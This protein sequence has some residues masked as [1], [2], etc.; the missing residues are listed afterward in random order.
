MALFKIFK[1]NVENLPLDKHE[2][3]AYFTVDTK[4]LYIDIDNNT[5]VQVNAEKLSR[6]IDN[7]TETIEIDDILEL[8]DHLINKNNP[9]ETTAKQVG[10]DPAGSA[11]S[12]LRSAMS[13]VDEKIAE[14]PTPD[15]SAQIEEHNTSL[16]AH[17]NR[18]W[19]SAE[20]DGE[21]G[22]IIPINADTLNGKPGSD[23][24]LKEDLKAQTISFTSSVGATGTNVQQAIDE[25]FTSA[26]NGK[27]LIADAITG[28][29]VSTSAD[30]TYATMAGNIE[31]IETGIDISDATLTAASELKKDIVAYSKT[32]KRIVGSLGQGT[33]NKP[34]ISVSSAGKITA[35]TSYTSGIIG[36]STVSNT[37]QLSTQ[38][39]TTITP[40]T[41]QK[42]AVATGKY[43]TGPVYVAGD[44][45]LV[46]SNIR[47]GVSIFG[48]SGSYTGNRGEIT[49]I[50]QSGNSITFYTDITLQSYILGSILLR[51]QDPY[52]SSFY[53]LIICFN[54]IDHISSGYVDSYGYYVSI[55]DYVE[56][57]IIS[58]SI[59]RRNMTV[60]DDYF[61]INFSNLYD[62]DY[63]LVSWGS[64]TRDGYSGKTI[65]TYN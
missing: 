45:D 17:D 32:G 30:D 42:T 46:P 34:S 65:F 39:G 6:T 13:Y 14:I 12:A 28:M 50:R 8:Q 24:A 9:H 58:S 47:S 57:N 1:G 26:S 27:E 19:V 61:T 54:Y 4:E 40:G 51:G 20:D 43:T 31:K 5:R 48:V 2:G 55:K 21:I 18:N 25:L 36:S 33:V 10:A 29:G 62:I 60:G 64:P 15:V 41:S 49:S 37:S 44:S 11:Q 53:S 16:T 3:Y 7:S 63:E 56:R 52:N 23:Y 59:S 35:S 22:D 38:S